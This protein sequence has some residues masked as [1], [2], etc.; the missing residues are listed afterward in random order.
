MASFYPAASV[1]TSNPLSN[2]RM[3]FQ[4]NSDQAA[5]QKLQLQ[6]ST[7]R[8]FQTP[9]EDISAAIKVLSSQR[10]QEFRTQTE[11]NLKQA[12]SILNVTETNL[13]QTQNLL[14]QVR[15]TAVEAA[16]NTLS[17]DQRT[18]LLNQVDGVLNRL[19][20]IANAKFGDQYIFAGSN[21][22]TDPVSLNNNAVVFSANNEKL[23]TISDYNA[24][25][26]T[27]VTAQ[28]VFGVRSNELVGTADLN[29]SVHEDTPLSIL[30]LGNGIRKGAIRLSS[31]TEAIEL[32]LSNAHNLGEVVDS[33]S[34][35]SLGGRQL[36][37][38]LS[39]SGID[40]DYVDGGGGL[41][42]IEDVGSGATATDLGINN[43]DSGS[44]S[45]SIGTDLNPILT[46]TTKV[47]QLFGGTG[48]PA[49]LSLRITQG[50]KNYI[51]NTNSL[52]T[53]ED[54]LNRIERTGANVDASI[55]PTGRFLQVQS[56]ESGSK[57]S[58]GENGDTL[59]TLLGLRSLTED[60]PLSQ[61]NGGD[62]VLLNP[63]GD[64]LLITRNDGST[65]RV[66]L[67]GSQTVGDVIERI[68]N[69]VGNFTAATRVE[70]SLATVG[71]GIVLT[72]LPGAQAVSVTNVGGSQAATGLGWT[73]K[74]NITKQSTVSGTGD[75]V[76]GGRDVS[77]V[78]VD[79][80]F[81]SLLKLRNAISN[82][83]YASMESIWGSLDQDLE[84]L[85]IARGFVGTRQ[86]DI[87]SRLEKSEDEIVQLKTIESDNADTDL[88][89]V[90]SELS[91]R[92]AALTASLQLLGQTARNTLFDYL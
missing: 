58:I 37:A 39:A 66:S 49:G 33:L 13:A 4:V 88:A 9:S 48:L 17:E 71:N 18:A 40:I 52:D 21:V 23:N 92:Q 63:S 64:D 53:V 72:S 74:D 85:S 65:F 42:R 10:Q 59:A 84:R 79:G 30:N 87:A 15:A 89:G 54:L 27:N 32:D 70:A 6:L 55:D 68:N 67:T 11:V 24:V 22:R 14:N 45:P 29:P 2:Y 8:R 60:T 77:G 43:T 16:N 35:V 80:V 20:E 82:E 78:E 36:V 73:D 62:G 91:Q 25:V 69:N 61:L 51:V 75:F 12:D 41:L 44:L 47:S 57:L 5:I 81:N 83:D 3:L 34:N 56:F 38:S 76:I 50:D 19:T 31:G 28:E 1:R 46:P 90:I 26:T 7:G 86:Q